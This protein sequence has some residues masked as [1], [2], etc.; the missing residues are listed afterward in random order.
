MTTFHK[1]IFCLLASSCTVATV[2]VAQQ[3]TTHYELGAVEVFGKPAEVYAAGSRVFSL[4]SSYLQTYSSASLAEALQTRTPLYLKSYGAS[5]LSSVS[6]RGTSA[7]HTAVLWNGLN[8]AIPSLGQNDF[9]TLPLSG[10]GDVAVQHGAAGATYGSGAIGGAVMLNSPDYTEKGFRAALQ[11]EVGSFGRYYS[12]ISAGYSSEKIAVGG[13]AY[14]QQAQNNFWYRNAGKFG[15]PRERMAHAGV[16]Q[17][18]FTQDVTWHLSPKTNLAFSSWYTYTDRELQPAMGAA[19]NNAAQLDKNL[20]LL[21]SFGHNSRWGQTSIKAAYFSDF[22]HYTDNH[23]NSRTDIG[24]WQL[25]AEQ[26]YTYGRRWSLKGGLNL[27]YFDAAVDGYGGKVTEKRAAAFALFRYEPVQRLA[28]SLN[29]RQ[30][31]VEGFNPVPTPTLGANWKFA[32]FGQHYISVKGNVSGSYRVPTLNERFWR[33]G[34]NPDLKPEQGWNYE[35]GL[36]HLFAKGAVVVETEATAYTIL[37]DNWVQWTDT[38]VGYWTPLNLQKVQSQGLEFSSRVSAKAGKAVV[39]AAAGYAFTSSEQVKSY[40]GAAAEL[41]RQLP[42]VPLHKATF[43]TDASYRT[44][45][46]IGNLTY[47]GRRY[48]TANN[49]ESMPGFTLLGLSVGK[50]FKLGRHQ[51]HTTLRTDNAT[52]TRYQ[53]MVNRAMPPRSYTFSLRYII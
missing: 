35:A 50:Q 52:N 9:A 13:S 48:T 2:A 24:T 23:N 36:R 15:A 22:L 8:I 39:G 33:P 29:L 18:G 4:D 1:F 49:S 6:F 32:R 31:F 19:D 7:S 44:W 43:S 34:G 40:E 20:R 17:H 21:T 11:Q 27:Q 47:T 16:A 10:V 25:Q 37:L 26:T 28:L 14:R 30:A 53:T 46:F 45:R 51:L 41:H 3:D 5:G 12:H 38:G 42:Y